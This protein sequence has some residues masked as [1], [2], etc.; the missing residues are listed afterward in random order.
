MEHR[1]VRLPS[2]QQLAGA[3]AAG[4]L[5]AFHS[6][7]SST[8]SSPVVTPRWLGDSGVTLVGSFVY[9][10]REGWLSSLSE[11]RADIQKASRALFV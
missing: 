9:F 5:A 6:S 3:G 1:F 8:C 4:W 11:M 7:Q 10:H 2:A